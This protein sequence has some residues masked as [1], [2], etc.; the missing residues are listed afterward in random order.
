M[1]LRVPFWMSGHAAAAAGDRVWKEKT[2]G[3]SSS[4]GLSVW[5]PSHVWDSWKLCGDFCWEVGAGFPLRV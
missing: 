1:R 5:D 2:P 3:L 4:E